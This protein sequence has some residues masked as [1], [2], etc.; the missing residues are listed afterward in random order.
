MMIVTCILC[1]KSF[2]ITSFIPENICLDCLE[3]SNLI[4]TYFKD[5]N[6]KAHYLKGCK[7][8]GIF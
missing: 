3:T 4:H 7:E 2:I 6:Y 8:L 5:T 1:G